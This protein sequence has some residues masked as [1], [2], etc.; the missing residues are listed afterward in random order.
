MKFRLLFRHK[1]L[2]LAIFV[3]IFISISLVT[4]TLILSEKGENIV[5]Q[6]ITERLHEL[7]RQT[8]A[9]FNKAH[10]IASDGVDEASGVSAIEE[11]TKITL[12]QQQ[13]YYDVVR[14]E[15]GAVAENVAKTLNNQ[16][17]ATNDSLD[18]L[19]IVATD[20]MD[21]I[22]EFDNNSLQML[23]SMAVFNVNNFN[24]ISTEGLKRLSRRM[25]VFD[26]LLWE[27][28]EENLD[29]IDEIWGE[30]FLGL[31]PFDT[32]S[33]KTTIR[34]L[35]KKFDQLKKNTETR[36]R[37]LFQQFLERF[38]IQSKI[39]AEEMRLLTKKVNYAINM[40]I[41]N[42]TA[43]QDE[44]IEKVITNLL[45]EKMTISDDISDSST[46]V[47]STVN[48]LKDRLLKI[49]EERSEITQNN[50][51]TQ[52]LDTKTLAEKAK[53]NVAHN[54]RQNTDD[55]QS[56]IEQ[57]IHDAKNVISSEMRKSSQSTILY[58]II[59]TAICTLAA[60]VASF[61]IIRT[62][63]E[64]L[65]NVL[66][67]AEKM[68][69]GN[70]S[71][72]LPERHDEIG[73]VS[74][75]LNAMADELDKLQKATLN[76]FNQTLDQVIDCVFAFDAETLQYSY[77]NQ[78]AILQVEYDR[79]ELYTMTPL[80]IQPDFTRESFEEM[81]ATLKKGEKDSLLFTTHHKAKSGHLIPVEV[82]LKYV[83]PPGNDPRY[84]A[85]VR[86]I[87]ERQEAKKE[88]DKIMAQLLHAQ[89]LESVGQL[90][91]G[92]AHEI[93]TPTQFIGTNI[94]FLSEAHQD[95]NSMMGEI[96][97]IAE[98]AP[99]EISS[100]LKDAM[101]DGDW[102]FLSEEIPQ[103]ISQ[104]REGIDR[105]ANIVLAMKSFS[106]P[107]TKEM[108][109]HNI[110]EII[111]TT[112][113]VASNEWK[114]CTEIDKDLS[115]DLPLVPILADEMGQVILNLLVNSVHAIKVKLGDNPEGLKG[116]IAIS[117]EQRGG[118]VLLTIKDNGC[119]IPENARPR[120]FDPFYTTK[121]VGQGTG[122]GLAISH[123]VITQKH[124]G[125]ISFETESDIGTTFTITLPLEQKGCS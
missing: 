105:V 92:I 52:T 58:S 117:T 39:I 55:A 79:E 19:L 124:N 29:D 53:N 41:E 70:L 21:K 99:K 71:E 38:T 110:N 60:V 50:I 108:A 43:I 7:Q 14:G 13:K 24:T 100:E 34:N 18:N 96:Q 4:A 81:L 48:S 85:I 102:E 42:S 25:E 98:S 103:A 6:G 51:A 101:E 30:V 82:L 57:T 9:E 87:T 72:R 89:K 47:K 1:I 77:V 113:T 63:A 97:T 95:I 23:S 68:S 94:E 114:Y 65:S 5:L 104:S 22:M 66:V 112:I 107:G 106:H 61:F 26:N 31:H 93:N 15:I 40:E 37:K 36:Q 120:I 83:V 125:S 90:A 78:G 49:L 91:A 109:K 86:D 45:I 119:G 123:D 62:L 74:G 59:I 73:E 32:E 27:M 84:I 75:A 122:Q 115:R 76:S 64:P 69:Q 80:D 33:K 3:S 10:Q 121:E 44:N 28:Q 88:K 56:K 118:S 67:F 46:Q 12:E 11:V 20:S 2:L 116:A 111:E 54:I 17:R 8:D 16:N 35:E